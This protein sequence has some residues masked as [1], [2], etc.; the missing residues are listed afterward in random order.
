VPLL[1][2]LHLHQLLQYLTLLTYVARQNA[3]CAHA[4]MTDQHSPPLLLLL[5]LRLLLSCQ[6]WGHAARQMTTPAS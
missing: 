6:A 5:L 3:A 1:Q 4:M 2:H